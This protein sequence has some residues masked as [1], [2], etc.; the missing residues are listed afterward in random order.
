MNIDETTVV[1]QAVRTAARTISGQAVV[2]VLDE[3]RL[4]TLNGVGTRVWELADGRT[5]RQIAEVVVAE[6]EIDP[7]T[8]FVDVC[9]F[10][11]E[12]SAVG[13]VEV[14]S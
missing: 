2:V 11:H 8:A 5:A 14:E 13:A 1:R 7:E 3:Q 4:H 6:F 12:L 9:K 10:L